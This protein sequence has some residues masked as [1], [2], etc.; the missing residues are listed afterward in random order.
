MIDVVEPDD[1]DE[2]PSDS[3]LELFDPTEY[4]ITPYREMP[5]QVTPSFFLLHYIDFV[6]MVIANGKPSQDTIRTYKENIGRFLNWCMKKSR[7]SPFKLTETHLEIYRAML[8]Q[9]TSVKGTAYDDNS[10][11]LH[12]VAIRAFYKAAMKHKLIGYNPAENIKV[13]CVYI[14]DRAFVYYTMEEIRHI[15]EYV[16]ANLPKL[17]AL[18]NLVCIYLM[19]VAG[20]RCVEVQRANREDIN[21]S[22]STMVIHGKGH[23]GIVYLEPTTV[24][25]IREYLECLD[26]QPFKIHSANGATPL[27]VTS[28]SN[29]CGTRLDR[30]TIRWNTNRILSALGMKT[31]G[32]SCHV[33]RHSCATALYKN[34]RDLRVVQETLRHRSPEITARYAHVVERMESR[35]TTALGKMLEF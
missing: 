7:M 34:T 31:K 20:L 8:Y 6:C 5:R 19:S 4:Q 12:F 15:V 21:W 17:D 26:K 30:Q 22:N 23:D 1:Y 9:K 11:H 13:K 32:A 35:P 24:G 33:F 10:I 2:S 27:I 28:A 18:R 25:I 16:R 29:R 14:N 3:E